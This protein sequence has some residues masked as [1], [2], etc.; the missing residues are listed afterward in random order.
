[1]SPS[2]PPS[3]PECTF[4]QY[5]NKLKTPA[6]ELRPKDDLD[7]GTNTRS[8]SQNVAPASSTTQQSSVSLRSSGA[9][10]RPSPVALRPS[11]V[12]KAT[13][14]T[15]SVPAVTVASASVTS[16]A[17]MAPRFPPKLHEN[18]RVPNVYG[19][20]KVEESKENADP[21]GVCVGG[22]WLRGHVRTIII[23]EEG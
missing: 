21:Q 12:A 5:V 2:A 23:G 7:T 9:A 17:I 14:I 13:V 19:F 4:S 22:A 15:T 1:M 8:S 3:P 6:R 18:G 16:A 20:A 11:P 10:L